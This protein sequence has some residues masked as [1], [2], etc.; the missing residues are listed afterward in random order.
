MSNEY[1]VLS[2]FATFLAF[3]EKAQ[4]VVWRD[5]I[6]PHLMVKVVLD[7]TSVHFVTTDERGT[8][9][10]LF[11]GFA[12]V[13]RFP[14]RE[15]VVERCSLVDRGNGLVSI[16][17]NG[18]HLS[19]AD[20]LRAAFRPPL[21]EG[22]LL[23]LYEE[24][25][26]VDRVLAR[27]WFSTSLGRVVPRYEIGLRPGFRLDLGG[28][29]Y[30]LTDMVRFGHIANSREIYLIYDKY[31]VE[32]LELYR[33]LIYFSAFGQDES[34]EMLS[35]C[36]SSFSKFGRYDGDYLII[37]DRSRA[38][39]VSLLYFVPPSRIHVINHLAV[40]VIDM[41]SA[42][43]RLAE[44]ARFDA[45]QPILYSDFDI[46]CNADIAPFL[47]RIFRTA[48][49]CL[50]TEGLIELVPYG[51]PLIEADA[52]APR[53]SALG[54]NSGVI[55]FRNV[56][57][58]RSIFSM[59]V[60]SLHCHLSHGLSRHAFEAY[61]QPVANYVFNKLRSFNSEVCDDYVHPW[62]PLDFEDIRGRG[63]VHF[64]GGVGSE[65]KIDRVRGYYHH[66]LQARAADP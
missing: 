5:T 53:R 51:W 34:Y 45:Y 19:A 28:I 42:R 49:I 4:C 17:T 6:R 9:W 16:E 31:K 15:G 25:S 30:A 46:I 38:S 52:H 26:I 20:P 22:A 65:H 60:N 8:T 24:G 11:P 63:L 47:E 44:V 29:D 2:S 39:I 32:R 40:D 58:V 36:I 37:T 56:E 1:L 18:F 41:V 21:E 62:P 10:F 50:R 12:E 14:S 7:G 27:T 35:L 13:S 33:P 54:F 61:D 59:V 64:C 55:G 48:D 43:F 23:W 3:D 66:V 57:S